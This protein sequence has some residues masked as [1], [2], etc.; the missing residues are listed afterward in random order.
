LNEFEL[1]EVQA[2]KAAMVGVHD[3]TLVAERGAENADGVKAVGLD[4]EVQWAERLH[5]GYTIR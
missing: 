2:G 3:L 1:F 4:F 5:D